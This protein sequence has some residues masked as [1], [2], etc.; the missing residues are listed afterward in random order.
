MNHSIRE[1]I[2]DTCKT[3]AGGCTIAGTAST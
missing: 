3:A 2:E 1:M